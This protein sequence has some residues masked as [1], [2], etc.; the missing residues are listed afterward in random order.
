MAYTGIAAVIYG[1]PDMTQARKLFSDWGLV[2]TRDGKSGVTFETGAGALL[3]AV[4]EDAPGLASRINAESNF[5]EIVWGVSDRRHLQTLA[6]DLSRDRDVRLDGAGT[7]HTVDDSG[8]HIGFRMWKP[9]PPRRR[10][11]TVFNQPGAR[12]RVDV[13]ATAYARALPYRVGHAAFFVPEVKV[14]ERFY[15]GRLGFRLSDRYAGGAAVF[16]R[17]AARCDHHNLFMLKSRTGGIDLHHFAY[18]VNDV[19]EVFGGGLYFSKQG[20][21]TA[22]GP[23]RHPISSAYFW[24]FRN[25]LG[26]MMEY[27]CDP[28]FITE[29]WRPHNYRVNRFSE[30][31]LADGIKVPEGGPMRP[32]LAMAKSIAAARTSR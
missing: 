20:W 2:K 12:E 11:R 17:Y 31:H 13:I 9:K 10:Q 21:T 22:V 5:R 28:D 7:L 29:K 25:P 19:H 18:E 24:Y 8:I 27:F 32:S 23:G 30:W 15:V 6:E 4:P 1:T 26:G 16:M 3:C 14:A